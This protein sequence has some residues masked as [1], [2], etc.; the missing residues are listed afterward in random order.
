MDPLGKAVVRAATEL[1]VPPQGF[2][3]P[4]RLAIVE[5]EGRGLLLA[6]VDGPLPAFHDVGE[7]GA[8]A[9]GRIWWHV[10]SK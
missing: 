8:D 1:L 3:S 2:S 10:P 9:E 6:V 5:A 4:H 7:L